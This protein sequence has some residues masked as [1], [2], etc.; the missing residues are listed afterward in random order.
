MNDK[1][2]SSVSQNIRNNLN[3][4]DSFHNLTTSKIKER[5][6]DIIPEE[7]YKD[8][9]FLDSNNE[10]DK[11]KKKQKEMDI[12]S[13]NIEKS[14]QNLNQPDLFYADLFSNLIFRKSHKF[15]SSSKILKNSIIL[16]KNEENQ[17]EEENNAN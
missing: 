3:V 13:L 17:L 8:K 14:T 9:I 7:N 1:L 10:S 15:H 6:P 12:I 2:A 4:F 11:K 16:E 5:S